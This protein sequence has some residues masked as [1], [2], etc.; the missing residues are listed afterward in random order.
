MK[1]II[2]IAI[3]LLFIGYANAQTGEKEKFTYYTSAN[4]YYN[5]AAKNYWYYDSTT[6]KWQS[7]TQLPKNYLIDSSKKITLY[8]DGA[9]I[10]Q[11]NAAHIKKYGTKAGPP[12]KNK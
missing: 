10:W 12:K 4:I 6:S 7:N 5:D 9:D 8:Y 2:T 1:Q 11:A 3:F